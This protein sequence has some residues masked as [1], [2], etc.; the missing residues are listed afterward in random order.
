[1]AIIVILA[2]FCDNVV[3][4][5]KAQ[6]ELSLITPNIQGGDWNK[7]MNTKVPNNKMVNPKNRK[8]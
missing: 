7:I 3:T 6:K 1:M 8:F 5:D 2:I 4:G